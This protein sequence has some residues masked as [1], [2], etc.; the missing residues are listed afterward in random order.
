MESASLW[1]FTL[2]PGWNRKETEVLR[3]AL[4]KFGVGNWSEIL[5][6]NCLPGKTVVQLNNQTQR[7]LG[8]QSTAE[9]AD[10][11]IDVLQVGLFN[12]TLQSPLVTRKGGIII[13]TGDRLK[14]DEIR[15]KVE[16]NRIKYELP[17]DAWSRIELP[18]PEASISNSVLLEQKKSELKALQQEL[19]QVKIKL[20]LKLSQ[21]RSLH[22]SEGTESQPKKTKV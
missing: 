22:H 1:N 12:S 5:E 20:N 14:T 10:L 11:H 13:N 15:K 6:C 4:M 3:L 16:E 8:Q 21:K 7:M 19:K 2:S 9:F 18:K 17:K